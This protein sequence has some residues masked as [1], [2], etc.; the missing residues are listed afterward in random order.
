MYNITIETLRKMQ[1]AGFSYPDY[2]HWLNRGMVYDYHDDEYVIGGFCGD[3]YSQQEREVARE[4][5][6]L[7][8]ADQL[9]SWL[10]DTDFKVSMDMENGYFSIEATDMINGAVYNGGGFTLADA[11][12]KVIMKI[13]KSKRRPYQ[14]KPMLRCEIVKRKVLTNDN[15]TK[16]CD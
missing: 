3:D 1:K 11:L 10:K 6:W 5:E 9:L 14:P 13:C 2:E 12:A 7:P 4:C 15:G 16:E 8:D